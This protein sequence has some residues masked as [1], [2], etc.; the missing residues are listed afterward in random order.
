DAGLD[1]TERR[2]L[3]LETEATQDRDDRG[4]HRFANDQIGP[5][6]VIEERDVGLLTSKQQR[7]SGARGAGSDDGNPHGLRRSVHAV[8]LIRFHPIPSR[9]PSMI[10]AASSRLTTPSSH[11]TTRL[12]LVPHRLK[13]TP[14]PGRGG[15][16]GTWYAFTTRRPKHCSSADG[17]SARSAQLNEKSSPVAVHGSTRSIRDSGRYF[18]NSI[19]TAL[20]SR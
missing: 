15:R 1:A 3:V 17:Q 13:N 8:H 18:R 4:H 14:T 11:D 6:S 7:Q 5:P 16:T 20:A 10:R 2:R 12:L 19:P 9:T